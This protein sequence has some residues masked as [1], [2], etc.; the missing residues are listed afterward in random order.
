M[1]TGVLLVNIGT[2]DAPTPEKVKI[3]L[4]EFLMDPYVIDLPYLL[5]W[6]LVKKI[7]TPKRSN[8]S[9]EA[10]QKIWTDRGSPLKFFTEDLRDGLS[11][12]LGERFEV[13]YAMRYQNPSIA[14]VLSSWKNSGFNRILVIPMYPQYSKSATQTCEQEVARQ[15]KDLGLQ[16]PVKFMSPFYRDPD[17]IGAEADLI[18]P[19]LQGADHILFSFHGLPVRQIKKMD[20]SGSHCLKSTK[21]CDEISSRNEKYCYRAQSFETARRIATSLKWPSQS[22]TVSFQSRLNQ[23]WIQPFTDDV[24]PMLARQNVK[25]LVVACPSFTTDCLETLEEVGIRAREQFLEAGGSELRLVPC[26]NASPVWVQALSRM[27]Q[28]I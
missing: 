11:S 15:V 14:A 9:A 2:P 7:I 25:K 17:F 16:I 12:E 6:F 10:Y 22:Y 18:R 19:D 1:K 24:L 3:Y 23:N 8:A 28:R 13:A 4:D 26:L 20:Q 5:R 21:C 27:I